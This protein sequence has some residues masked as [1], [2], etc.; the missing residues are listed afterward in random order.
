MI[1]IIGCK[2]NRD[3]KIFLSKEK[4]L[5]IIFPKLKAWFECYSNTKVK[6]KLKKTNILD[7][8]IIGVYLESNIELNNINQKD[9]D[10]FAIFFKPEKTIS[11][12]EKQ[13]LEKIFNNSYKSWPINKISRID[14]LNDA[15]LIEYFNSEQMAYID[16]RKVHENVYSSLFITN[17]LDSEAKISPMIFILNLINIKNRLLTS[18][19]YFELKEINS[20]EKAYCNND[21]IMLKFIEENE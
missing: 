19:F 16:S 1:F 21:Q 11:L 14:A 9:L 6:D 18:A 7:R 8:D 15:K 2:S 5:N 4:E 13:D 12:K 10:N 3:G 20:Y 17:R